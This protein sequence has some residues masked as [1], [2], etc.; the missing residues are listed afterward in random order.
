MNNALA[1]KSDSTHTHSQYA[2]TTAMNNALDD[3]ADADHIHED[4][5]TNT[6]YT[7]GLSTKANTSHTHSQ[8][9]TTTAMNTALEGKS[10]TSHTH[11]NY[12]SSTHNHNSVYATV[13]HTHSTISNDLNVTGII[14]CQGNQMIYLNT[15]A[16]NTVL[17]TN[18]YNT[19]IGSK[20]NTTINGDRVY[21]GSILS[22]SPS[23]LNLGNSSN[24]WKNVYLVNSPN[25]SSDERLK[26]D[27]QSLDREQLAEFINQIDVVQ[28]KYRDDEKE[29]IGVIAQQLM[30]ADEKVAG[31]FIEEENNEN[32]YLSVKPADLVFPL[33]AAVQ[34]LKKEVEA[35]KNK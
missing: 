4:Y 27:I 23:N 20:E 25:V 6:D 8:Y 5:V 32:R 11:N 15:S 22:N 26:E 33:I 17:G 28:F 24:R 34:Q 31:Y 3:K 13:G 1:T 21:T 14:K 30:K 16:G 35:L 18:N 10:N 19:I 12:A 2:T 9:A 7:A 29:R